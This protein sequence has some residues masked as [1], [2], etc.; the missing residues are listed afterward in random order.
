M[1]I[2]LDIADECI[3]QMFVKEAMSVLN[4]ERCYGDD[5]EMKQKSREWA[6][7]TLWL[8]GDVDGD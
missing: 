5:E 1:K 8:Y 6:E 2:E 7:L 4:D 3:D